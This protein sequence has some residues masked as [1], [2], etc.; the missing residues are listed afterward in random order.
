[1]SRVKQPKIGN[2]TEIY[3]LLIRAG[4]SPQEAY[5]RFYPLVAQLGDEAMQELEQAHSEAESRWRNFQTEFLAWLRQFPLVTSVSGN[6]EFISVTKAVEEYGIPRATLSLACRDK[7]IAAK[8][9]GGAWQILRASL[10]AWL[11]KDKD[12]NINNEKQEEGQ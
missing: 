4:L 2:I 9:S 3:L 1:M 6:S 7:E 11:K 10:E 5:Q 8:K 12:K